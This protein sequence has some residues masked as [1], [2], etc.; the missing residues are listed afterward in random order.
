MSFYYSLHCEK[1]GA[2]L[3]Y[4][5]EETL[6]AYDQDEEGLDIIPGYAVYDYLVYVCVSCG[7]PVRLTYKQIEEMEREHL[8]ELRAKLKLAQAGKVFEFNRSNSK[9]LSEIDKYKEMEVKYRMEQVA[10]QAKKLND[11]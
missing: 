8:A 11:L 9:Y 6:K 5:T 1:C 2:S 3:S 7:L 4:S 10:A